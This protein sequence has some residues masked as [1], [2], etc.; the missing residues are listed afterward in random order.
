MS[1]F[2]HNLWDLNKLNDCAKR[3]CP[4]WISNKFIRNYNRERILNATKEYWETDQFQDIILEYKNLHQ[5]CLDIQDETGYCYKLINTYP[6]PY[7]DPNFAIWDEYNNSEDTL[8]YDQSKCV[9]RESTSYVA[10]KIFEATGTWPSPTDLI[11]I[12]PSDYFKFL[13]ESGYR[14]IVD[15][16]K[17]TGYYVGI[18]K[19]PEEYGQVLWYEGIT[20]DHSRIIS[21]TYKNR[22][23]IY[24][25]SSPKEYTWIKII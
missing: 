10:W 16:P 1:I 7:S 8:I 23:H 22:S 9:I 6:W 12:K 13:A 15:L 2:F 21:S 18:N 4:K 3:S 20:K 24:V 17:D 19:T 14:E 25:G 5:N 11:W